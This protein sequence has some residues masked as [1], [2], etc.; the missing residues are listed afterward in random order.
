MINDALQQPII[1]GNT[2]G[3]STSANSIISVV[4][5]TAIKVTPTGNITLTVISRRK[6]LYGEELPKKQNLSS[7]TVNLHPCH[8]FPV[9][10][11]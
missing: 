9:V 6:Y 4:V 1:I 5:G 2:Y 10:I 8:L 3:Y 7:N 11:K